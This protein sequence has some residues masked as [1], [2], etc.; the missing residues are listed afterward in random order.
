MS[1]LIITAPERI[2]TQIFSGSTELTFNE[3]DF[4]SYLIQA[5]KVAAMD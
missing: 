1:L 5:Y 3:A 2:F 4:K